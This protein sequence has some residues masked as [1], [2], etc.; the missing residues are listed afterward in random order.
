[1]FVNGNELKAPVREKCDIC[2]IGAGVAGIVLANELKNYP[3]RVVLVEGGDINFSMESQEVYKADGKPDIFPDPNYSRLRF[4]G[5]SSNHWE[6]NTCPFDPIDFEYRDWIPNSGWPI[7]YQ[8]IAPFYVQAQKYVGVESN[9]Y[10]AD[11]W[12]KKLGLKD[13]WS[14]SKVCRTG[15]SKYAFTPSRFFA[16]HGESLKKQENLAIYYNT[17]LL[18]VGYEPSTEKVTSAHCRTFSGQD[19]HIEA[20]AFVICL[21]GLENARALL[22]FNEMH[23]DKI[24]NQ[25]GSVGC[26]FME[27]PTARATQ[28]AS[29][30]DEKE[31][32][33]YEFHQRDEGGVLGYT[34]LSKS[35]LQDNQTVNIRVPFTRSTQ[36]EMSDGISSSHIL[37]SIFKGNWPDEAGSHFYNVI[38]DLDMVMEAVARK[39]FDSKL[40]EHAD[41]FGGFTS[42][43]MM[44][45]TPER[46]NRLVLGNS[47]DKFGKKRLTVD[48]RVTQS[49]KDMFWKSMDLIAKEFGA[50]G[51]GRARLLKERSSRIWSSQLGFGQHHMGTTRMSENPET[52]VVDKDSRVFGTS[53][54]FMGG[55]SVF[56]T[57]GHVPPTLTICALSVRLARYL[58]SEVTTA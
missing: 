42:P 32:Q 43:S 40:F 27:H 10:E 6:N 13:I 46:S 33:L 3:G 50:Q 45:Q 47:K 58:E 57:G 56:S 44:E 1:M 17:N 53:N 12:S 48:F 54:L 19:I 18:D 31:F 24:G 9:G 51:L 37:K 16:N 34:C 36:Y 22:S 23:N 14:D 41:H 26:Y 30:K 38:S 39:S 15:I 25:K 5:G 29:N 35:A 7:S 55:S 28:F 11:F 21:G 2:I 49:D 8:D 20:G 52:G 4:L